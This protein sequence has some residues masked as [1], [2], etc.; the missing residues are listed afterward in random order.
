[1]C[2]VH[3]LVIAL[4][5]LGV[6]SAEEGLCSPASCA[7]G[8]CYCTDRKN[9]WFNGG[10]AC[11]KDSKGCECNCDNAATSCQ[12][13]R[14][15]DG[16]TQFETFGFDLGTYTNVGCYFDDPLKGRIESGPIWYDFCYKRK[17]RCESEMCEYGESLVGCGRE[18]AGSCQKCPDLVPVKFW[19]SK[20][21]CTQN[22][23]SVAPSGKFIAK[24]CTTTTDTVLA[25]CAGYPGNK[26]YLVPNARD[27]YYCPGGGLVL[28]LPENSR[29]TVDY[30]GYV[31]IDG[32][33]QSGASC[34]Q[35]TPGFACK[36]GRRFECPTYY[37]SS[38]FA[39][40][41]CRLCTRT[42]TDSWQYPVR[43][44]QGSTADP[45]C[46]SCGACDYDPKRGMSCVTEAYEMGG[47]G[48]ECVPGDVA[49]AV[50]VCS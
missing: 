10:F 26:G 9:G 50:A 4:C 24:P 37:Y 2:C 46:V 16:W 36:H 43:C 42:C 15:D 48:G 23:C 17:A 13:R 49:G 31:C 45:G 19:A 22:L 41:R 8:S 18:S 30:S 35:C 44:A 21:S 47:L 29:P 39:M 33:Y 14:C 27:T 5:V 34:V 32:F 7:D 28:P 38:T 6:C 12:E 11:S 1:M 3:L 20:G 40:D 25:D